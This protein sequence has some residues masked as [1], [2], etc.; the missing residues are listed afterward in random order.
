MTR[1]R[2]IATDLDGTFLA[3]DGSVSAPNAR[4]VARAAE[5]G[6]PFVAVTGRPS[7]WLGPV[8]GLPGLHPTVIV[9]NG[10]A[11]FDLSSGRH[12]RVRGI[13]PAAA[14]SLAAD[15]REAVPGIQFGVEN[16]DSFGC[17]P[18]CPSAE[19]EVPGTAVGALTTL[20]DGGA[21]VLKLLGYHDDLE[22][23]ALALRAAAACAGRLT[24]THSTWRGRPGLI[25][26]SAAGTDKGA[27][28]RDLC[29]DLDIAAADVAAFGDMPNDASMLAWSG[30]PFVVA[31]AHPSL[32]MDAYQVVEDNDSSGVGRTV[33]RLLR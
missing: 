25:E 33:R 3:A 28:L 26:F 12:R 29:A 32:L 7:R 5:L 27:A 16:G 30:H 19:R 18:D 2:L 31:N 10:A 24:L 4:A 9:S 13:D 17:E 1:P 14:L 6:I 23:E 22:S 15:L 21:P 20:L 8:A 11:C